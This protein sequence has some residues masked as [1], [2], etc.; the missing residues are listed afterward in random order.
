MVNP[1]IKWP[2]NNPLPN[3]ERFTHEVRGI[4]QILLAFASVSIVEYFYS[5]YCMSVVCADSLPS[6]NMI[7]QGHPPHRKRIDNNVE[8][9]PP[10]LPYA[11]P[12][13]LPG[14]N[15]TIHPRDNDTIHLPQNND[16]IHLPRNNDTI[17]AHHVR[18]GIR[19]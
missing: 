5:V 18:V 10:R 2:V 16:T 17:H 3:P 7:K 11:P 15:D 8:S 1:P 19:V 12:L 9:H 4:M 13:R 6:S 14:N